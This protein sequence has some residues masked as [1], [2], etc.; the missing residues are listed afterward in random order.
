MTRPL[1]TMNELPSELK[2]SYDRVAGRYTEEYFEELKRKPFDRKLL[3]E[4]AENV[5][6]WGRC[7]KSVVAQG[8]SRGIYRIVESV[9]A[10]LICRR[11]WLGV[12]LA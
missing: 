1:A 9:C 6:S 2:A 8:R 3:D 5:R 12:R 11:R 10:V 7:A 4:F